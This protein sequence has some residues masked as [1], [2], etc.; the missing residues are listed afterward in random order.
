[1]PSP[2]KRTDAEILTAYEKVGSVHKAGELLGLNHSS[3]H[4][5]LVKMGRSRSANTFTEADINLLRREYLRYR[6]AGKLGELAKRMGR[7][8]HYICRKAR[9]LGL[10]DQRHARRYSA[11][12]KYMPEW[13]ARAIMDSFKATNLTLGR[14]CEEQG[15]DELGF[16]RTMTKYFPD[17]YEHVIESKAPSTSRYRR[18]RAFE[19]RVKASLSGAGYFVLRSPASRSPLDLVAIKPGVVLF[20]QC[21]TSGALPPS[22]WNAVYDLAKGTGAVPLLACRHGRKSLRCYRLMDRKDGSR[23]RQPF[24]LFKP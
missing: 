14:F 9:S 5:R 8:K 23:R 16:W 6:D 11:V 17:E 19:Y 1:M 3:V 18:G 7:T 20:V 2:R 12:W 21:K 4:E 22:E 24:E 10:T 13:E 15:Y